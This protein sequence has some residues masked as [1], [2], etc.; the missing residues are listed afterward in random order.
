M[1]KIVIDT[2]VLVSSLIQVGYP[3]LIVDFLFSNNKV[4]LC[5]SDDLLKE[6]LDVLHRKKFSKYPDFIVN[7]KLLL[8]DIEKYAIKYRP[9]VKLNVIT[10]YSD[11]K[12]LELS[13]TS[14]A[15]FLITGNS[16]HFPMKE[17]KKTK[18]VSPREFWEIVISNYHE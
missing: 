18:V 15:E 12:L 9:V 13:E 6:Y 10:D 3:F 8:S 14:G 17:Y 5:V 7:A 2:N 16:N 1:L 11:N 4:E